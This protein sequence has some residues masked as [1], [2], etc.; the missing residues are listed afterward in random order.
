M[1]TIILGISLA[2]LDGTIVNLALPGIARDLNASASQ[3][4]W[5]VNAYQIAILAL[6]LPLAMLG[7]L[8]GYRRIYLLGLALF[9]AASFAC[10]M[11][12]SLPM[13][14][15]ARTVQGMGAAGLMAVNAALVRLV[16]PQRLLGQ[17][18]AINSIVVAT[19]SVAGPSIAAAILSVAGWPWLFA[20]NLPLG[21]VVLLLG[22]RAIPPNATPPIPGARLPMNDALLNAAM[23]ILVFL[24]AEGFVAYAGG[25]QPAS[26]LTRPVVLL[27]AGVAVGV[28]HLQRQRRQA[29]PLFPID[30]LRIP[31]FRL[32]ICT[33]IGAF[34]AQMLTAIALPFLLLNALGRTP[35]EAGIVLTAWPL[36]TV[37]VAP[38]A[39]RLI[40]RFPVGLLGGIGL[41]AMGI[42]LVL[43]AWLPQLP[44]L[45]DMVWRMVICGLGFG[46]FQ[47][48][49]NHAIVTTAP[50][51][52]S[53]GASGMLGTARLTGQS[54]AAV[55]MALLFALS[56]PH[57]G[58]APLIAI[59]LAALC[60]FTA[61][62][63]S[64][65]RL[66]HPGAD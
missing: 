16:Y 30:L 35:A 37:A 2:T 58:R 22:S 31:L 1:A 3:V 34:A 49:N 40:G 43:L 57:G 44:S 19:S 46:L 45:A 6:L 32:S 52:R 53:G 4:V 59:G 39:G 51:H 61:S 10:A 11:S 36:A 66:R 25:E 12:R 18:L 15:A 13:L 9:T 29:L 42:G 5:V 62:G 7:D 60:A 55:M 8:V 23:F 65:L 63:F 54:V 21:V 64:L 48:P 28:F 24:G 41:A 33:S 38:I 17:G 27:L 47:S 20:V 56:A 50:M 14:L 26:S